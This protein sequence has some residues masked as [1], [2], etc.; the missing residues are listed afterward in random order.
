MRLS[1]SHNGGHLE[2]WPLFWHIDY[3]ETVLN[4]KFGFCK[5]E[6]VQIDIKITKIDLLYPNICEK[7]TFTETKWPPS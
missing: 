2:K 5:S 3:S 6:N 7:L 4:I 1:P